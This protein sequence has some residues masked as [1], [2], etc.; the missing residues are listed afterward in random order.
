LTR[1]TKSMPVQIGAASHS[2]SDPT[3]LLSDCHRRV[4]MFL[5]SL[6]AVADLEGRT[7]SDEA[8]RSLD[9]ALRYFRDAAPKHTADEEISLF[10]VLRTI[11]DPALQAALSKLDA[12][13]E[14]HRWAEPLHT[15]LDHLGACYLRDGELPSDQAREFAD[16]INQLQ[17]MYERHIAVEDEQ[18]FPIAAR[19][20][21]ADEKVRIANQMAQRRNLKPIT[22]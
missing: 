2:F 15:R 22:L 18:V 13:E 12:L 19:V 14:D 5:R 16:A 17:H 21:S 1:Y 8:R 7:L 3:G 20:L 10:P 11:S 9:L 6:R 4:E